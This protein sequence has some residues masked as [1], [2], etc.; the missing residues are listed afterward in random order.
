MAPRRR[1]AEPRNALVAAATG[2]KLTEKAPKVKRDAWQEDAWGYFDEVPE[3][4]ELVLWRGNQLAKLRLFVGVL[5]SDAGPDADPIP[6]SDPASGVSP[7][8]A[9]TAEA[10]LARLKSRYGGQ[11][12]I[13]RRLEVNLEVAAE[14]YIVGFG[15]R[16]PSAPGGDDGE[17]EDW[18]VCS[19]SEATTR[20]G[21]WVIKRSETDKQGRELDPERDTIFRVWQPH[22]RWGDKADCSFRGILNECESLLLLGNQVKAEARSRASAGILCV[23]NGLS[24][25]GLNPVEPEEATAEEGQDA[26][27][28]QFMEELTKALVTPA[29]DPSSAAAVVPLLLRGPAEE[30]S[31][32]KL[33]YLQLGRQSDGVLEQ[34]IEKLV[35]R[36]ARGLNAP[37]EV[38]TGL[39]QTTF[40]NAEQVDQ[41]V[42]ED[43][44]EPRAVFVAD[45]LTV[46]YLRPQLIDAGATPEDADRLFVWF[47][48]SQLV[49]SPDTDANA[50][51][52][53]DRNAIS[54][55]AYR[56][57]KGYSEDD[58][59]E[60]LEVLVRA[61]LRRGIL[62]ADLT[63]ALIQALADDAGVDLPSNPGA[64]APG[65]DA[66]A[67]AARVRAVASLLVRALGT[68]G[69]GHHPPDL[70][71]LPPG[72]GPLLAAARRRRAGETAGRELAGIDRSLRERLLVLSNAH[73]TRALEKAG[74][75]LRGRSGLRDQL[76][77]V[78]PELCAATLGPALVAQAG[79]EDGD[80]LAGAFDAMEAEF[81]AWGARAQKDAMEV[82]GRIVG[83]FSLG[84]RNAL[85]LRQAD[86]LAEAWTWMKDTLTSLARGKLYDPTPSAAPLGEF[87]PNLRVPPGLVR[88]AVARAGGAAGIA[89]GGSGDA[90]V[91]ITGDGRPA[92]GVGTGELVR[93]VLRDH[94][95][96]VEGYEWDYGP[97]YR[98]A[99]FEPHV[100]LHGLRFVNFDDPALANRE[101]FPPFPYYMPGDHAGCMCDATPIILT[102]E[103]A[104]LTV[105][106]PPED[107]V[108]EEDVYPDTL[109]ASKQVGDWM[110]QRWGLDTAGK[111]RYFDFS[112]MAPEAANATARALHELMLKYPQVAERV[113]TAGASAKVTAALRQAARG[114]RIPGMGGNTYADAIREFGSIRVN[115]SKAATARYSELLASLERDVATGFHPPGTGSVE[116]IVKHEFG[117]HLFWAARDANGTD[118]MRQVGD[119]LA[120]ETLRHTGVGRMDV[121]FPAAQS[122]TV[123]ELLSRYGATNMDELVAEAFAEVETSPTPR[124]FARAIVEVVVRNLPP[125]T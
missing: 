45:A 121:G 83:G 10:E 99:P 75:K 119:V 25:G 97:A 21:K 65:G 69:N 61:G 98:K 117:H 5:P 18:T 60:P 33:R 79:V 26:V 115:G 70:L 63:S 100:Q 7:E 74:N 29:A 43:Y 13:L 86:D 27:E 8:L 2:I 6:A 118:V 72:P 39:M 125:A 122:R 85:G 46:G 104:G 101:G 112:G 76:R 105:E 68:N 71:E 52:A 67:Q 24:I 78:P 47:D 82:V 55:A 88:Q 77:R 4:K 3:V 90:W 1:R 81:M 64:G 114:Y 58:A 44:L 62:T 17:P 15:E 53:F 42:W 93:G 50:D 103:E 116:G 30:M 35:M 57:Y 48:P 91:A 106:P 120:D 84:E 22:A 31:P 94:G 20:A 11:P 107:V 14:A 111:R 123:R 37:V 51:E 73:M 109:T 40:A 23:P 34:R 12:E 38:V 16:P 66:S 124:P 96:G 108:P 113:R 95:A 56:R 59:P 36:A 9:A 54:E 80:L 32:D 87:D 49:R 102:P 89:T 110:M 28:D 19:I 92:G 41:D